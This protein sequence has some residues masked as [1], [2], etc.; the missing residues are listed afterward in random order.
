MTTP[1]LITRR[2]SPK[3]ISLLDAVADI[4]PGAISLHATD[5]D[6]A[7]RERVARFLM[8]HGELLRI[9]KLRPRQGDYLR[10]DLRGV[11]FAVHCPH[12]QTLD[13]Q[14]VVFNDSVFAHPALRDLK[15]VESKYVGGPQIVIGATAPL[16]KVEFEECHVKADVLTI[17]P[18]SPLK[19][20]RYSL[21]EDYAEECPDR[22]D[23][24]GAGL[25][26]IAINACWTY[27]VTTSPAARRRNW[28]WT[29][30]A[31][32]YGSVT[33]IDRYTNSSTGAEEEA[34]HHYGTR[35]D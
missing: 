20:F 32:Q 23:V 7:G 1:K 26:T 25:E 34:V 27:T 21:D 6:E 30:R 3:N 31:G 29:F 24:L 16:R 14:R 15:L 18:E 28:K 35:E 33:H 12:L 10:A 4:E 13:V 9:L 2:I 22:F 17:A 5:L 11:D 19:V 8:E